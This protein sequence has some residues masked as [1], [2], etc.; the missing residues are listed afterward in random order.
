[1]PSLPHMS[2][3]PNPVMMWI[4]NISLSYAQRNEGSIRFRR[5]GGIPLQPS[6]IFICFHFILTRGQDHSTLFK[7]I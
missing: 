3:F 1:M 2:E 5:W 6:T 7:L 4:G